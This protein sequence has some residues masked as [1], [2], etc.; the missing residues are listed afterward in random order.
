VTP[1]VS[2]VIPLYGEFRWLR[3]ALKSLLEDGFSDW[4][5]VLI[6]DG[7]P[8]SPEPHLRDFLADPRFRSFRKPH[9]GIAGARNEGARES[10]GEWIAFLDQDDI[11]LPGRFGRQLASAE[12]VPE[13]GKVAVVYSDYER[14]DEQGVLIDRYV[15][16]EVPAEGLP[17]AILGDRGP[18]AL[19]TALIRREWLERA[20]G[21]DA[22]IPGFDEGDL[23]LRIAREGGVFL[24]AP[25]VV[26]RWRNHPGNTMKT[27]AFEKARMAYVEKVRAMAKT[28]ARIAAAF[29]AF[30]SRS[31][32]ARG[33]HHAERG[34]WR[35]AAA[36]CWRAWRLDPL[37]LGALYL[38][39]KSA[40]KRTAS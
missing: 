7:S 17:G 13:P 22:R 19:G 37:R 29:R 8:A 5:A 4:E 3:A 40:V 23:F 9:S 6:D 38:A 36:F 2:V 1:R 32:Y 24:Y 28:D 14:I 18:V 12:T 10:R 30:E 27:L 20:G 33:L 31:L 34:Q 39:L 11:T 25:G 21:F 16:R 26:H 15:S 35:E